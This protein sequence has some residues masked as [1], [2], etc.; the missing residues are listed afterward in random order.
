MSKIE[1][2]VRSFMGDL[3]CAQALL[4]IY[5]PALGLDREIAIRIADA[6]GGGMG[7]T[8]ETCG[9]VTGSL[10]VLSLK[11]GGPANGDAPDGRRVHR[12][13]SSFIE[14]FRDRNG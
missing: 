11:Y 2:A 14:R 9:A 10:M 12:V 13:A 6:F 7:R 8:G 5:G 4:S 3:D 1:A